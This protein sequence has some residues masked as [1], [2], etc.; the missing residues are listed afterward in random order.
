MAAIQPV[1]FT[2]GTIGRI[3][4]FINGPGFGWSE[5]YYLS[6]TNET[7][8]FFSDAFAAGALL[9]LN[10]KGVLPK[11]LNLVAMRA[12]MLGFGIHRSQLKFAPSFNLGPTGL[13]VPIG[14]PWVGWLYSEE[15]ISGAITGQRIFRGWPATDVVGYEVGG[16][17]LPM[18]LPKSV[19]KL[20][21][22]MNLILGS[23]G[24]G[25]GGGSYTWVIPGYNRVEAGPGP[26]P[27]SPI[28]N[29][30]NV[31]LDA[32]NRLMLTI[33]VDDPL[34]VKNGFVLV[35]TSRSKCI[36]GVSGKSRVISVN[37]AGP[38]PVITLA[39]RF[40]CPG[41][42]LTTIT[43][44]VRNYVPVYYQYGKTTA[45]IPGST[46][47]SPNPSPL[48][49]KR[50]VERKVGKQFFGTAGKGKAKCC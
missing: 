26:P 44:T 1:P 43:G 30:T 2:G 33:D 19:Q 28:R 27:S 21:Q 41:A 36:T 34:I 35:H 8:D 45:I 17:K 47:L 38:L 6:I 31:T 49:A 50:T 20:Q 18:G 25:P 48:S 46:T 9:V 5:S 15:D 39:K 22:S 37:R 16:P 14:P 13:D 7:T 42:D 10:R 29:I 23:S 3:V 32:M 40:C 4:L 11:T 12:E 24:R